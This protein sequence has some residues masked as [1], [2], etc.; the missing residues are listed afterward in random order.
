MTAAKRAGESRSS[1]ILI[2]GALLL[3]VLLWT[4]PTIGLLVSSIRYRNDIAQTGWWTV[5]PHREWVKVAELPLPEGDRTKPM[6]IEGVTA[7]FEAF[8]NGVESADGKRIRWVGNRRAGRIEVQSQQWTAN[9]NFTTENYQNVLS[10]KQ[11]RIQLPSGDVQTKQ[12]PDFSGAF[13]NSLAVTIPATIIPILIA[14]FAAYGFAWMQF[15]GRKIFFIGVILLLVVP[16]QVA[17]VPLLR[18][19]VTLN[20]N[21]TFLALCGRPAKGRRP[22]LVRQRHR[23][24]DRPDH[25]ASHNRAVRWLRHDAWRGWRRLILEGD[26]QLDLRHERPEDGTQGHRRQLAQVK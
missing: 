17:L 9:T 5:F 26:D 11:Y 18:D 20:L 24:Q 22:E 16:L 3:L 6:T 4:I 25:P 8:R 15:P 1:K 21:G 7:T 14:A 12:G 10:G 19:F 13:L 23:A 2:N